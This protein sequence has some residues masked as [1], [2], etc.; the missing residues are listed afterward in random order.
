M[1]LYCWW[2]GCEPHPQDPSEYPSCIRCGYDVSYGDMVGDSRHQR[3]KDFM[4]RA[5]R[6][7]WPK[8]CSACG[9]RYKPCDESIDHIPF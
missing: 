6:T 2:F 1:A 7:I 9:R 8:K 5:W 4:Y 3:A